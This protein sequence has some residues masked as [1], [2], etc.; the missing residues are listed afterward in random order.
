MVLPIFITSSGLYQTH[1][2]KLKFKHY[3]VVASILG[4]TLVGS[5][6]ADYRIWGFIFCTIGNVYWIWYHKNITK[7]NETL[8]IFIAYLIINSVAIV[9]NY[10]GG[11]T[12]FAL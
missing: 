12:V 6:N 9:N 2:N 10:S 11:H 4:A 7:D 8:W 5:I 3:F 1:L